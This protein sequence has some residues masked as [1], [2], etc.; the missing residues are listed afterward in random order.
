MDKKEIHYKD[1]VGSSNAHRD[2]LYELSEQKS[3]KVLSNK[4]KQ[5]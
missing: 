5:S 3:L 1:I 2:T 4:G